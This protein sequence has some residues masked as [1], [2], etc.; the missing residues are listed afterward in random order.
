[1][2]IAPW[3]LY[4]CP[5]RNDNPEIEKVADELYENLSKE[6][7]VLYDDRKLSAGAKLTDSELMGIPVRV[8][9]SPRSLAENNAE[10]TIRETGEKLMVKLDNLCETLKE[11]TQ[12]K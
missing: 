7:E 1:M 11:L 12:I 4:L 2:S 3:L 8:V 9:I 6:F 10:I 5:L